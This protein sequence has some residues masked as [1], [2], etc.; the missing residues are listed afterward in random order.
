[1]SQ[2]VAVTGAE[3]FIGSHL[4]E[5]LVASGARVRAMVL[6]NSFSSWGWLEGLPAAV[7][8]N[9]EVV[10]GDVRDPHSVRE[11]VAGVEAI[12]HLAALIAIPYS[13]RAPHS[14]L[15][16]NG[17]GTLNVLEAARFH[18]TP[19]IVCTSTSEVYGT[20][21]R[22]PIDET[23]PLQAQSPY[24]ASKIAGDKLAESY[25]LSFDLPVVTLRPFNTFGPRQSARAVI[26]TV[27]SQLAAGRATVRLG[28]LDPTRDFTFVTDTAAAFRAV[29][30]APA[31]RVVGRVLNAG[32][33]VEISIRELVATIAQLMGREV[34]IE[35]DDQ[36]LRPEA[37]EVQ[38]LVADSTRLREATGWAPTLTLAEGLR[39]TIGW[40]SVPENLAGYKTSV[41]NV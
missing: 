18:Q 19:R 5:A 15:E 29:A 38:R 1:M 14:Y 31:E 17:G 3:G 26:P 30:D 37:S 4:V 41:Y 36:R 23:H 40:F 39:R 6:Y 33:G 24:S 28:A 27:I 22:V 8:D 16:T 10:L 13:Y 21:Q 35:Q 2:L 20:A 7:L 34:A 11:F 32:T 12:Y 25:H 9:V